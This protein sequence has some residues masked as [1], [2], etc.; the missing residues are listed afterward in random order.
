MSTEAASTKQKTRRAYQIT[1]IHKARAALKQ[2]E[3]K[4]LDGRTRTGKLRAQLVRD[5]GREEH[6]DTEPDTR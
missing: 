6:L 4:P 2:L 3:P 5:M 1:G